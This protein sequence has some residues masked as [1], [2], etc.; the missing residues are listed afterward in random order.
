MSITDRIKARLKRPQNPIRQTSK[1]TP[2]SMP[3]R[4]RQ[5]AA[6]LEAH[7]GQTEFIERIRAAADAIEEME[8]ALNAIS[9]T[10]QDPK[11]KAL[12]NEALDRCESMR[13]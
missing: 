7:Y 5:N 10:S 12:A 4:L 1:R 9:L 2:I 6:G 11:A 8:L 3:T 13:K